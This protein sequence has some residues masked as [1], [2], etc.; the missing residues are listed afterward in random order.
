MIERAHRVLYG[1]NAYI[2][3]RLETINL[4]RETDKEIAWGCSDRD[5]VVALRNKFNLSL[6]SLW[7]EETK[8]SYELFRDNIYSTLTELGIG[9]KAPGKPVPGKKDK[10][11]PYI[12][13]GLH[14]IFS[15]DNLN[16]KF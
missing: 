3:L 8:E 13:E 15:S 1:G 10:A 16:K 2:D 9:I 11:L 6:E 14:T 12:M 4:L 7:N 5:I